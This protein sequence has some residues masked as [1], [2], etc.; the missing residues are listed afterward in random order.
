LALNT[1]I[2]LASGSPRRRELLDQ[3]GVSYRVVP[4]DIDESIA[5][6]E[7]PETYT[8]RIAGEKVQAVAP[9]RDEGEIILGADTTVVLGRRILGKPRDVT[10]AGEM[11]RSLSARSHRVYTAVAVMD[12]QGVIADSLNVSEVA[13]DELDDDWIAAYVATG[14]PLDKAGA[15]G[16]Q[17]WAGSRIRR[18]NGSHS[19]IMGLPL[20]E[21]AK[22]L[23]EAGLDL[24]Q[25]RVAKA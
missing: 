25:L 18:V 7:G 14:E 19:A 4:A 16:I 13:F 23:A 1:Q 17:G 12:R 11:L 21:T 2:M 3:I 24:P 5:R 22:L 10:E 15:Y 9:Q 6:G 8:R 20:Y